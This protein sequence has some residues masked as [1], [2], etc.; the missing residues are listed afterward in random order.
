MKI[1]IACEFSG[2][3]RNEFIK[4]GHDAV[5]CDIIDSELPGPHIKDDV[6]NHLNENWEMM[7]AHPPCT[8]LSN[9]GNRHLYKN[10]GIFNKQINN[11][12]Y[13]IGLLGKEFFMKLYNANIN[14]I[15]VENPVPNKLYDLPKYTQI[16]QPY[17]F[18]HPYQ[19][20]TCLW[21]KNLPMLKSANIIKNAIS[22]NNADWF[23]NCGMG[24]KRRK[25]RSRTFKGIAEAMAN[26]WG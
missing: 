19:K 8:Y 10:P 26:Q 15:C 25:N 5:S 24:D 1:L 14:K 3:V 4:I 13:K 23:N 11:D 7:I 2:I 16:I 12:R 18:G 6:L 17:E 22:T 21:L 9:A 20:R